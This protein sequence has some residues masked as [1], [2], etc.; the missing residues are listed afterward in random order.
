MGVLEALHH[1]EVR[2]PEDM[3]VVGFL[4]PEWFDI[5]SPPLTTYDLPLKEMGGMAAQ[6]LLQR[7]REGADRA[8]REP[9]TVRF[10]GRMVVRKST[11]PP[12]STK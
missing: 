12:R 8:A 6:L 5:A 10:E 7:I 1:S 3:S 11:A 9:H 2:V 4:N